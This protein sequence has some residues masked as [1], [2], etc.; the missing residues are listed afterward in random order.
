VIGA[1]ALCGIPPFAGFFSK[2]TILEAVHHSH[3]P[4][5]GVAY[6][7]V[8][9]GVLITALYTFRMI[10][11]TFHGKERFDTAGSSHG[12]HGGPSGHGHDEHG[13]HGGAHDDGKGHDAHA[14]DGHDHGHA[15]PPR[16]SPWVVTVPLVAL[17]IPSIYA[18]WAYAGPLLYEGF[19]G[20]SI[21]VDP[22]HDPLLALREHWTGPAGFALHG[23]TGPPFWLAL[24]GIVAAWYLYVKRPGLPAAIARR[25]RPLYALLAN[26]YYVDE[27]YQA[28]FAGGAL[29]IGRGFWK[30][31]DMGV[32]DGLFVNG[33]AAVVGWFAGVIRRVQSGFIYHYAFMMI[34]G[35]LALLTLWFARA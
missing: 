28:V 4:G 19:F 20:A 21:F 15:G 23:L 11:M 33:S 10:F 31:G 29:R 22:A 6:V 12:A 16:E 30:I 9:G 14:H 7:A 18:G 27:I 25:L 32:I 17:A 8:L 2:D 24:A 35:V 1:L 34:I 5:A 13:A 3:T 26:K